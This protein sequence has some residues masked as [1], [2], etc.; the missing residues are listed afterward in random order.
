MLKKITIFTYILFS[1]FNSSFS[2]ENKDSI[3]LKNS[4]KIDL[5][6]MYNTFFDNKVQIRIGAEYEKLIQKNSSISCYLDI[7]VY[8]KYNFIKYYNFFNEN[9]GMYSVKQNVT[10]KGFHL[11]PAYNYFFYNSKKNNERYAFVSA[12]LDFSCYKKN[13]SY[14]NSQTLETD[15]NSYNQKRTGIGLGLGVKN[16]LGKHFSIELKTAFFT[17][18][19][20]YISNIDKQTIRPMNSQWNSQNLNFWWINNLKIG[21]VFN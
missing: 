7:G 4:L 8:D 20:V 19:F 3:Y 11:L 18:I 17:K 6:S 1:I 16:N 14:L 13:F 10:V 5:L 15:K 21:Y 9:Q 12:M 2:Q